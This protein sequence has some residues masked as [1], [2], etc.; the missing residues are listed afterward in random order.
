WVEST[1]GE[2]STFHFTVQVQK[3]LGSGEFQMPYFSVP[4][5][6]GRRVL[7][8]DDIEINRRI[9]RH[10]VE[11][12]GMLP[13]ET[14]SSQEALGWVRRG[15]AFD[16][17][18][19]DYQMPELD[20]VNLARSL[21]ELR[22][23]AS[24]PILI[25]SS[26]ATE[27]PPLSGVAEAM[28]KPIKPSRLLEA[29]SKVLVQTVPAPRVEPPA[30]FHLPKTL[31]AEHPLRIL[32]AEDNAMNRKLAKMLF[33]KMGYDP[34][35]VSDGNEALEAVERQRYD[36]VFMD[37]LMP[38]MDG[39]DATRELVRRSE[40]PGARQRPR[41][42]GMSANAMTGDRRTAEIAGMDDYVPKPVSVD[43]LV[44]ALKRCER[45]EG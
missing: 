30:P 12:W 44:A 37:V 17:A 6:R 9:L 41:I 40:L 31:G 20:G 27:L 7:I 39:L 2:G 29:V 5:L 43:L 18:L 33:E 8:V 10:Y 14:A 15:D 13:V 26:A 19:L 1:L 21:R 25:L 23:E 34:D 24:L 32:V 22:S 45:L 36:V 35:F 16:L 28:V 38:V 4:A 11:L 3:I 42:V